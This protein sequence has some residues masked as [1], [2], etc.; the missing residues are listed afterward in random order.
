MPH[1]VKRK[2][3]QPPLL[4]AGLTWYS[5]IDR[6]DCDKVDFAFIEVR[7]GTKRHYH[8]KFTEFC[9]V[10]NGSI[11]VEVDGTKEK[12]EKGSIIQIAPNTKHKMYGN[13]DVLV[14]CSPPWT[15]ED[16]IV[17]E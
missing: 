11:E 16:E 4:F 14:V 10:L 1:I 12:L 2:S 3:E 13:A 8:K 7:G 6:K 15:A 5:L 9:Y 17:V